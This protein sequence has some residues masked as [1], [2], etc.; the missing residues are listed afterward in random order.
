M[1]DQPKHRA[2]EARHKAQTPDD[3]ARTDLDALFPGTR[4]T[5]P[6]NQKHK[7]APPKR[8]PRK[9]AALAAVAATGTMA[10]VYG[11]ATAKTPTIEPAAAA[12]QDAPQDYPDVELQPSVQT[13]NIPITEPD[14]PKVNTEAAPPPPPPVEAPKPAPAPP[15]AAAPA[16]VVAEA[17]PAPQPVAPAPTD[18]GAATRAAI[19]AAAYAQIGE[20]QDCVKMVADAL[21]QVGIYW[22]KWPVEY[23]QIGHAVSAAEALPGDL[24]YYVN[25]TGASVAGLAHIAIYVGDGMAIHGGWNGWTTIKFSVNVGSG[26]NYI[27]VT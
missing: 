1:S 19:V 2:H 7:P 11:L 23:Y 21:A 18:K 25:G 24:I 4:S 3:P 22:Y 26:P 14:S 20:S 17:A 15:Q 5:L 16:P 13:A 27:R 6:Q 8:K 9:G 10:I 12:E